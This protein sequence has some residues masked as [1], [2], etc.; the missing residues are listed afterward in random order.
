MH[1]ERQKER[2]R[3]RGCVVSRREGQFSASRVG[4]FGANGSRQCRLGG[5]GRSDLISIPSLPS[6]YPTL[7]HRWEAD[8]QIG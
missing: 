1:Q 3:K 4:L 5:N 8:R 7:A 6:L 2:E